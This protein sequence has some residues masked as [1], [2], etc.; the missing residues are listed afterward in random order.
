MTTISDGNLLTLISELKPEGFD[1]YYR[2]PS[3]NANEEIASFIK[4]MG[5][6]FQQSTKFIDFLKAQFKRVRNEQKQV[7]ADDQYDETMAIRDQW[8]TCQSTIDRT[9][10]LIQRSLD[11]DPEDSVKKI[12]LDL[13]QSLEAE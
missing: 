11:T 9:L 7:D 10:G 6:D 12:L 2:S 13:K 4:D 8:L 5:F 1:T 3:I